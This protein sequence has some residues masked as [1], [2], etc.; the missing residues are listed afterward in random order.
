LSGCS[1]GGQKGIVNGQTRDLDCTKASEHHMQPIVRAHKMHHQTSDRV[2]SASFGIMRGANTMDDQTGSTRDWLDLLEHAIDSAAEGITLS[3]T[4]LPDNPIIYANEGFERL[5]GYTRQDVIG[6]NCRFLQG[7]TTDP[8]TVSEIRDAIEQGTECTVELLN[9]KKDGTPFWNRLSLTPLP[10]SSGRVAHFVGVQSDIT[11]LKE[12]RDR[13]ESA[14]RELEK[15]RQDITQQIEQARKAQLFLLPQEMPQNDQLRIVSKYAPMARIG[16]DFLD[17]VSM[18][19]DAYGILV[20]DVTGHGIHAALLAFMSAMAF[21]SADP[22]QDST[23]RVLRAVNRALY[24][25]LHDAYFVAM[26]YAIL[27]TKAQSLTY[28]QAGNPPALLVRPRTREIVRL[29][30]PGIV[31]G[32]FPVASLEEKRIDLEPGDKV[33][34]YT[35]AIVESANPDGE[36]LGVGGLQSFL[37]QH[38]DLPIEALVDRV[39]AL[40]QEHS[41]K[42]Y[43]DDDFTLVGLQLAD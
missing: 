12:T 38:S 14:N 29:E 34:F 17:V 16:G 11:E 7:Q 36:M 22:R 8:H 3:D 19:G 27:D 15:F 28:T 37:E 9:H 21:K 33:L 1:T 30:T 43:Y 13:L 41:G 5:T 2:E 35:D 26:F 31:I 32:L 39:Y 42:E 24:G 10:D 4:S 6:R 40:G 25:K 20:A 23:E 18:S